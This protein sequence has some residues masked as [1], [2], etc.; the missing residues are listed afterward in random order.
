MVDGKLGGMPKQIAFEVSK[1]Q[2]NELRRAVKYDKRA[3]V[4]K[5]ATAIRLLVRGDKPAAVAQVMGVSEVSIYGW[6][7]RYQRGGV[8]AL[9]NRAKGRPETKADSSYLQELAR[10]IEQEPCALGYTFAV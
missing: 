2:E 7:H 3:E 4:Q 9:A 5:R 6:W 10:A 1:E 8:E